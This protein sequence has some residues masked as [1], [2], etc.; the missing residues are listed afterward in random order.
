MFIV[1]AANLTGPIPNASP[2][3]SSIIDDDYPLVGETLGIW[4]LLRGL[5]RGGMGEVYEAE[6]D[7]IHL[8][9]LQYPEKERLL[10]RQELE[11]LPRSEQA[12]L[13]SE[14]LGSQ[15]DEDAH[16][17][18]KVCTAR[19]GTSAHKRFLQEA[20][21]AKNLGDHP[22]IVTVHSIYAGSEEAESDV[23]SLPL[24]R[25]KHSDVAYMVMELAV[26]RYSATRM[27][28]KDA[29]HVIR[30][31]ATA[32]DH[33][34]ANGIVHRD[35]KPENILGDTQTPLLTDFGIAKEVDHG[36]GLTRTG[37]II[38]TLDYMS[39][40]QATDAKHVD[41]R[42]DIYSL[43]VVLYEFASGGCLP[44]YHLSERE[45]CLAAIRSSRTEP[46]WPRQYVPGFPKSL[47]WIILKAMAHKPDER[48][49][50][51]TDF[52]AD[53]DK[54]SRGAFISF[55]GRVHPRRLFYYVKVNHPGWLWGV[56]AAL[57]LLLI[58]WGGLVFKDSMD[59][60]KNGLREGLNRLEDIHKEF[61]DQTVKRQLIHSDDLLMVQNMT[62]TFQQHLDKYPDL[63]EKF[64]TILSD[65]KTKRRLSIRFTGDK[66]SLARDRLKAATAND[67]GKWVLID[68]VG[69]SG[70]LVTADE[71]WNMSPFG[72]GF[73]YNYFQGLVYPGF[74]MHITE[75]ERP[76]HRVWLKHEGTQVKLYFQQDE[77]Q[78][79]VL[80]T[81]Q[82]RNGPFVMRCALFVSD[83]ELIFYWPGVKKRFEQM[84]L[85][86]G[87]PVRIRYE[88]PKQSVV[89][90]MHVG[91]EK[92]RR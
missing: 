87:S 84:C 89:D 83:Q 38:G 10:V 41:L 56:P 78:P 30:C 40:E 77:M 48:Y 13:A 23:T 4:R 36:T 29:V 75:A 18:I 86:S 6:Y 52:I 64:E 45:D 19:V 59:D 5:G 21:W 24:N 42:T 79:Q 85:R 63:Q 43:G 22:Y 74:T 55:V 65:I 50:S 14:L 44:Y 7:F 17:A 62:E 11:Q 80:F 16:F 27:S 72:Q 47:E 82:V 28:I 35:L 3:S 12:R 15:M 20:E 61:S 91:F 53:L 68:E 70:L 2:L 71:E 66:V 9:G 88:V 34:H 46:R 58:I 1:M 25:G 33:A 90:Q 39:P 60:T 69:R 26:R 51:M 31:V 67:G 76:T 37:Q 73:V 81:K 49:Q 92:P 8:L 32:L 54:Y 57:A